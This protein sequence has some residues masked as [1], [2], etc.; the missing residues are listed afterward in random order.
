M[1]DGTRNGGTATGG[2][3]GSPA[4]RTSSPRPPDRVSSARGRPTSPP[5]GWLTSLLVWLTLAASLAS[6]SSLFQ[7][8]GWWFA[9]AGVAAVVLG[10]S[11]GA[12]ALGAGPVLG[13][14]A[15]LVSGVLVTS[16][17]VSGGT[18]VLGVVPTAATLQRLRDL[19]DQATTTI[20]EGTA[21]VE[22]QDGLLAVVVAAVLGV[23]V[24]SDLVS[25]V[26]RMPGLTGAFPAVVLAVPS[27][28]PGTAVRWPWVVIAVL[29]WIALL[30]VSTGRRP[31]RA[32]A[33]GGVAAVGV[34]ALLTA[35]VPFGGVAPLTGVGTGTGLA[36]G[37]NPV[38]DL[39]DDLRRGAPLTVLTY[40]SS[41]ADG[42][43]LKLVD[44]VDFS[45]RT[46]SPADAEIDPADGLEAIP[47]APG[48]ADGTSRRVVSTEV[49][50][51]ALRSPYL[52]VPV[53]PQTITGLDDGWSFVDQSGVTVR[54]TSESTQ[55]L[56]YTVESRPVDP[57]PEQVVAALSDQGTDMSTY[58][59]V[60]GVP[61]T[62]TDLAA[63]VTADAANPFDAAVALQDWFRDGDF[64]YSEDTP[65]DEGYDGNGLDAVERF[66]EV[67]S[68]YCVHFASAMAVM[69]RTLGIPS[70]MAVGFLPGTPTGFG[71]ETARAVS[72]DDLHTWP[73]LYF[74]GLGWL[75]FEPTV[76]LGTPQSYLQETGVEPTAAPSAPDE[77]T[78]EP[79]ADEPS[80]V[81]SAA[82]P[83][84]GAEETQG[85]SAQSGASS[86]VAVA[87]GALGLAVLA[88]LLVVP[89][90]MRLAR[91][92]RRLTASPPDRALGAWREVLDTALDLGVAPPAGATPST[93]AAALDGVLRSATRPDEEARR[94]LASLSAALEAE[95]FGGDP[96]GAVVADD[97]RRVLRALRASSPPGRRVAAT[98][99]P[100]SLVRPSE[101]RS[102]VG[103]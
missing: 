91:R 28:V 83:T 63:E 60:D 33:V 11:L 77:A 10:A 5:T 32:T 7:G 39:G 69:A 37:V 29:C 90:G 43:Y 98:L 70:R 99:A 95:R 62:V 87:G 97:A 4:P 46:W 66:L 19:G 54:S 53:P 103:A 42:T 85:A 100:R 81:P 52:P 6:L 72:S 30:A 51:G 101:A 74:E 26:G 67:K 86:P 50:I 25:T 57:S 41:D 78:P 23:A 21:P 31:T 35:V 47:D 80:A 3:A 22:V 27:F 12:R 20:V 34:A 59:S 94:A 79:S 36:T 65:V 71:D 73:E 89:S 84:P 40:R 45:G 9:G 49:Q 24:V 18:A 17:L 61:Q 14:V 58:L 102:G 15:G 16:A 13:W 64:T 8:A 68:G 2:R 1:V 76:G 38:V 48:I 75:P 93:A 56:E 44:L 88:A 55:G 96:A 82:G 92:R